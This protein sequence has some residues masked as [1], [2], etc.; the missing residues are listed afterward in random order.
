MKPNK[1]LL[2]QV[3]SEQIADLKQYAHK[4]IS[5]PSSGEI[6]ADSLRRA[7]NQNDVEGVDEDVLE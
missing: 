3:K 6:S 4:R 2:E 7:L 5:D 1:K